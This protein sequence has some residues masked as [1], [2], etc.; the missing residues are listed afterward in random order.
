L[1]CVELRGCVPASYRK[2]EMKRIWAPWRKEYIEEGSP[3]GCIFC[4]KPADGDDRKNHIVKRA[5][6][7]FCMLNR[8]PYNGGHLMVAPYRHI[9]DL[10]GL[11]VKEI[12]NL[13]VMVRD[14]VS[15]LKEK[16]SPDAFNIGSNIGRVAGAG[17]TAHFHIHIVPRWNGDTNFMPV[18]AGTK[19]IP[20]S[21]DDMYG[22]LTGG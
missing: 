12:T 22:I 4:D 1:P 18:V 21:L 19:V 17:I 20:H 10:D 8:Y 7:C 13:M 15:L 3:Q 9:A 11:E 2:E 5:E 16:L 6:T 14:S